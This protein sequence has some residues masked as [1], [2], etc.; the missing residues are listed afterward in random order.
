MAKFKNYNRKRRQMTDEQKKAAAERLAAARAKKAALR[1]DTSPKNV[2]PKVLALPEDDPLSYNTVKQWIKELKDY[3]P[4]LKRQA[5]AGEKGATNKLV[6][7]EKYIRD[8]EFYIRTGNWISLFHGSQAQNITQWRCVTPAYYHE[9]KYKGE[10]KR[11]IGTIYSDVG[12]WTK[13]MN[14]KYFKL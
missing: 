11:S 14:D 7:I 12:L 8:C 3:L 1:G 2:H 5:K 6:H 4:H 13:E 10:M 9:G